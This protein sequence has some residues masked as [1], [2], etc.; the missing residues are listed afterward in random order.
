MRNYMY[1]IGDTAYLK[2]TMGGIPIGAT[3]T[4]VGRY[5]DNEMCYYNILDNNN[6]VEGIAENLLSDRPPFEVLYAIKI[7]LFSPKR[8]KDKKQDV[9]QISYVLGNREMANSIYMS[10]VEEYKAVTYDKCYYGK[11]VLYYPTVSKDG[12]ILEYA[13][14][15]KILNQ[16]LFFSEG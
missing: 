2:A 12:R 6:V 13:D 16:Y 4:I 3:V 5:E 14:E 10:K 11:C 15:D 9:Y 1:A 7:E 8:Y